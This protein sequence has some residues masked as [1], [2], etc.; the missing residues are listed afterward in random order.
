VATA[1][2]DAIA[3]LQ[4]LLRQCCAELETAP[5]AVVRGALEGDRAESSPGPTLFSPGTPTTTDESVLDGSAGPRWRPLLVG[6]PPGVEQLVGIIKPPLDVIV[7]LL[8][9]VAALLDVLKALLLG[10]P[11]PFLALIEAAYQALKAIIDDLLAAGVYL[12]FDAPGLSSP[13]ISLAEVGLAPDLPTAFELGRAAEVGPAVTPDGFDRWA[14][15]FGASFDDPG[16]AD[17]PILSDGAS[18]EAVFIVGAAPTLDA[19]TR[20][21]YLLGTLFN[22]D[23]F[24]RAVDRYAPGTDDPAMD[25]IRG[26]SVAPDWTSA[27]LVDLFPPLEALGRIPELLRGLL[28]KVEGVIG[29]L[30]E[31]ASAIQAKVQALLEMAEMVQAII[32]LLAALSGAGLYTLPVATNE[33]IRGLTTAFREAADRPPGGYLAGVCMLA[34]GPGLADATVLWEM[35]AG[36]GFVEAGAQAWEQIEDA[37]EI[38]ADAAVEL[39]ESAA[40]AYDDM[41]EAV[42]S[43]PEDTVAAL[44]RTRDELE[45]MV[46][47]APD[48]LYA[49]LEDAKEVHVDQA[50]EKGHKKARD[51]EK[52]GEAQLALYLDA[53]AR[54]DAETRRAAKERK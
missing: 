48:A 33:G 46:V 4:L 26:R 52:S 38:A 2:A 54:R 21:A 18:V 34:A 47:G 9:V 49:L 20:F 22:L 24:K 5:A 10:L 42:R 11:D 50:I 19:L 37:G 25:R 16:D 43:L 1:T 8:R 27:T 41:V 31:L 6:L 28:L 15:R 23:A 40:Q 53:E 39:G 29:M 45:A 30:A 35:I 7:T 17:R 36:G 13:E 32:D 51:L 3:D 14:T 44:G 12:Y